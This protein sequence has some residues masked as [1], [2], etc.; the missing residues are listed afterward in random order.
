ML[1]DRPVKRR[2]GRESTRDKARD[3]YLVE[4]QVGVQFADR[5]GD[6][7]LFFE[8]A[9]LSFANDRVRFVVFQQRRVDLF[10]AL[11]IFDRFLIHASQSCDTA[12]G[13]LELLLE[14]IETLPSDGLLRAVQGGL[15][16]LLEY[17]PFLIA[18]R[19]ETPV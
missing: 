11:E 19:G 4:F 8:K 12:T 15:E 10:G 5:F 9:D 13:R 3:V 18:Q 6:L 1:L 16:H 14:L 17:Q 2:N 7:V